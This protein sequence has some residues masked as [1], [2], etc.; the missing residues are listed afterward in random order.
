MSAL[1]ASALLAAPFAGVMAWLLVER[2]AADPGEPPPPVRAVDLIPVL[3]WARVLAGGERRAA[4]A[5]AAVELGAVAL[6]VWA[7]LIMPAPWVWPSCALAWMLL[8]ASAVDA[9]VRLLPDG[10]N[11]AIA[12]IGL[13]SAVPLGASVL[14]D[15]A[16]GAVIGLVVFAGFAK[17]YLRLRG[18]EGLGLGDAKL[19]AA[20][21]AWV[22]WQ[23]LASVVVLASAA[24]LISVVGLAL[25]QRRL[26]RA[27]SMLPLG[28]FL[29]LGGWL[30][31]LYG[32]LGVASML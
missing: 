26:P 8:A 15:R 12:A 6:A 27:S 10:I 9:R 14:L 1:A 22:G 2:C 18:R 7:W 29:A 4:A 16:L 25:I 13:A 5:R 30:T 24:A 17:L 21:G 11:L 3:G 32:P 23:G 31:W 20:L 28:P 19:L